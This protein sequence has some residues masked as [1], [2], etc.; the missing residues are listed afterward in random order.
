MHERE[1]RVSKKKDGKKRSK[2]N[3][4]VN[5]G[6]RSTR[7]KKRNQRTKIVKKVNTTKK[8]IV[9]KLPFES[10]NNDVVKTVA[11]ESAQDIISNISNSAEN[12]PDQ[13]RVQK[14]QN[15]S[16]ASDHFF[17]DTP[18]TNFFLIIYTLSIIIFLAAGYA[19]PATEDDIVKGK[20]IWNY[21]DGNYERGLFSQLYASM[22]FTFGVFLL[23]YY[24][25]ATFIR[26]NVRKWN[27]FAS[28]ILLMFF[29]GLGK[30]GELVYDHDLFDGFKNFI[31]SIA[32]IALAFASYKIYKDMN[33]VI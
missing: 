32:L 18:K 17:H 27:F 2:N 14:N 21:D 19:Y 11:T 22:A 25:N 5:E 8:K 1:P 31:L 20:V 3:K 7:R 13:N 28:G 10:K 6:S 16:I 26:F 4:V 33:G 23:G 30:I 15:P 24:A 9:K 12:F 29:F